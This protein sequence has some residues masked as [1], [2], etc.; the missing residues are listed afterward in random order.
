[1]ITHPRPEVNGGLVKPSL[2][3]GMSKMGVI[4]LDVGL[5]S[6]HYQRNFTRPVWILCQC[7]CCLFLSFP[8]KWV[9]LVWKNIKWIFIYQGM[10]L[11]IYTQFKLHYYHYNDLTMSVMASQ[12]TSLTIVYSTVYLRRRS[13]KTSKET[14]EFHAQMAGYAE[15]AS[16]SWRHHVYCVYITLYI[17]LLTLM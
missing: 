15:N 6:F 17:P 14:G 13:K 2:K 7:F 1:M 4:K 5:A 8:R 11:V 9:L 12:I 3:L 10:S 16:I